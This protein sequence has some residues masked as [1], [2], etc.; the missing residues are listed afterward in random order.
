M[1]GDKFMLLKNV[2]K[3]ET[4]STLVYDQI[5]RFLNKHGYSSLE[6]KKAYERD[7][8]QFFKVVRG[9]EINQLTV[10]DIQITLDDFEDFIAELKS[11]VKENG[12]AKYTNK[13]VNRKVIAAKEL[14]KYLASKK[15]NN[16]RYFVEDI[17]YLINVT[18][19]PETTDS[20]GILSTEEVFQ[21]AQLALEERKLGEIKRLAILLSFDICVRKSAL[22]KLKWSDFI[23]RENDVLIKGIDKGNK[24][25][26]E[27]ISK[28]FYEEL[29]T[30]KK[31]D[32]EYVFN[33]SKVAIDN[34]FARLRKKMNI[35]PSRHITWHSLKKSGVTFRYRLTGSIL[36]AQRAAKHSRLETT[37]IYLEN[38]DYNAPIGAVST[39]GKLN[40]NLYKEVD[41]ET[42][43]KGIEKCGNQFKT[44]LN[45]KL[46]EILNKN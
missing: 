6:T 43:Q 34:C 13:T 40:M 8:K 16:E 32:S 9:K 30:I 11:Y 44:I 26:R 41:L 45:I 37:R 42:L 14:L 39:C 17:S 46:Q 24:E 10:K 12:E 4:E 2:V 1:D 33:I 22:L 25:F 35:D 3:L 27:T 21:M 23:V 18:S 31:P 28:D 7:I 15:I 36:E 5:Q 19:L 20:Y 38:E 29:L